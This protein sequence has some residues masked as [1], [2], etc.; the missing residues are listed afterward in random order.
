MGLQKHLRLYRRRAADRN[1]SIELQLLSLA[2]QNLPTMLMVNVAAALGAIY[3]VYSDG[4]PFFIYWIIAIVVLTLFRFLTWIKFNGVA[5]NPAIYLQNFQTWKLIY[6]I[7]LSLAALFW[8][9]I[10][11]CTFS[12]VNYESKFTITIIISA[13]AGGATGIIASL[14][15]LGGL[16]ISILLLAT[17]LILYLTSSDYIVISLLGIIFWIAMI[18]THQRNHLVLVQSLSLQLENNS[19]ITNLKELNSSLEKRVTERTN[20][21]KQIANHDSLTGLPNRRGLIE[22][23]EASLDK[24]LNE[25]A[26]ILFLDLDRFKQINDAMGHDTGDLVLQTIALRFKDLCPQ[27]AIL[28]RWGGDEFLLITSHRK[29]VRKFSEELAKQLIDAATAP[30]KMNKEVLGL[31]LSVGIAYFPTDAFNYHDVIQAADLTVAEVKRSGRGQSLIFNETYAETQRRRFDLSRALSNAIEQDKLALVYQPIVDVQSGNIN[32]LEALARW[33]HPVLGEIN[34]E[35]FINLAED[36]D[37]IIALGNWVLNAACATA[38]KWQESNPSTKIAVN[39]SLKQL[40]AINF[41]FKV[42]QILTEHNL[43]ANNL[44]LEVT[45]SLFGIDYLDSTLA[46]VKSLRQKGIEVH[47]DDFGIGYSSL[48]RLHE[49][50]VTAIKIDRSFVKQ[51]DKQGAVIIESAI[52]IAKRMNLK[53]TAEGVETL[54]QAKML[55]KLGVDNFQGFY[56]SKPL[57]EPMLESI[58]PNWLE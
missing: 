37:R 42:D 1:L 13:L 3:A 48:S 28:G 30:L 2:Y 40:L 32:A 21:L 47:I 23:M 51:L 10:A 20:A 52:M 56:F 26:A 14:K 49:F 55:S 12:T 7:G 45:E 5:R 43:N 41:S 46:T 58:H 24:D 27:D 31:G 57:I 38:T 53:V 50:P 36:T 11:A 44:I 9:G 54:N 39:V 16:Y 17:S 15:Y 8:V 25:E 29:N 19:L 4:Y 33:Q 6:A 34:P 22:W 18:I 35:E